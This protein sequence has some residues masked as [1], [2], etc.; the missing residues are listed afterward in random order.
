MQKYQGKQFILIFH[1][2]LRDEGG[3]LLKSQLN[4]LNDGGSKT[5]FEFI[6]ETKVKEIKFID[7]FKMNFAIYPN[8]VINELFLQANY[9]V[10]YLNLIIFETL[11]KDESLYSY[12]FQLYKFL[13]IT[14]K[15]IQLLKN[16]GI[17]FDFN[18]L[19]KKRVYEQTDNKEEKEKQK[20]EYI[21][22]YKDYI[23]IYKRLIRLDVIKESQNYPQMTDK[24]KQ[25]E[26]QAKEDKEIIFQITKKFECNTKLKTYNVYSIKE[27]KKKKFKKK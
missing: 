21:F 4:N 7:S 25:F 27:I 16:S 22:S 2:E 24:L 14:P 5:V 6:I 3:L 15:D 8:S 26:T 19:F 17:S 13:G 10:G 23:L 18:T 11:N 20:P 9:K 1:R 12:S